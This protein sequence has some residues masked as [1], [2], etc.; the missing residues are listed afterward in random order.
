MA[1]TKDWVFIFPI[2]AA[3]VL[4]ISLLF[5]IMAVRIFYSGIIDPAIVGDL[6]PFGGGIMDLL[7]PYLLLVPDLSSLQ[8]GF[9]GV[10]IAF[11]I[12]FILGAL[13][14]IISGIRVKTGSKELKKARRKWLRNGISYILSEIIL[15]LI[16]AYGVQFGF[17]QLGLVGIEINFFMR[18][19]M[20]LIIVAGGVLIFAY[21]LA[22]AAG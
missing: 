17:E 7:A 9:L 4:L 21:I 19:G 14:L 8:T 2:I 1:E 3:A 12:F 5:P 15:F 11:S 22:K 18:T 6:L 16:L 13:L 20:I 10:G